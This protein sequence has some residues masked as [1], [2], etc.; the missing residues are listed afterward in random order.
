MVLAL[1]AATSMKHTHLLTTPIGLHLGAPKKALICR[2][3]RE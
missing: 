1:C 3:R 2:S